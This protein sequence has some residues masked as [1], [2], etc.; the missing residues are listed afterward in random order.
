MVA[1]SGGGGSG[2]QKTTFFSKGL[3]GTDDR[4]EQ[5]DDGSFLFIP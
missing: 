1:G 5:S 3:A 4:V 2:A